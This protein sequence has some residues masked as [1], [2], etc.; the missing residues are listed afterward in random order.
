MVELR[1]QL[2]YSQTKRKLAFFFFNIADSRVL[3]TIHSIDF[4]VIGVYLTVV[5][6]MGIWIGRGK[7][8]IA[9]YLL[10]GRN[11]PWWAL[12]GSIVATETS[13]VT[14]LSIPGLTY[15]E[16][17]DLR[18]LQLALGFLVGRG[19]IVVLLLPQYFRGRPFTAYQVLDRRFG[20]ATKRTASVLFLITRNLADG[21]RLFLTA[22]VLRE[23]VGWSLPVCILIIGLTTIVYT[24]IGGM[25][26]VVWNDC[27]Q[28]IVYLAGGVGALVIITRALPDGWQQLW[29]FA[30][31]HDKLRL[32][33]FRLDLRDQFTFWAGVVGGTFLSLGTHGTDQLMVQRYLC[34]RSQ[35][36]A[37][38]A[39]LLSGFA[40][41]AQFALFLLIGIGL[42]CYDDQ[43][44]SGT[45]LIH[46]DQVFAAF[47][48]DHLPVGLAGLT[49]AA[50]FAAAMSRLSSSLN[51]S[52]T[53]TVNDLYLSVARESLSPEHLVAI[54]R[55]WTVVFGLIQIGVGIAAERFA[56]HVVNDVLA[57]AG[58]TTGILLGV[59]LLGVLT[60]RVGQTAALTGM[61]VGIT[62][63]TYV[64]FQT[65]LAW[66]WYA[67]VG[68]TATFAAGLAASLVWTR[69]MSPPK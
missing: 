19:L 65:E 12:L 8:G 38:R 25:K 53:S 49:L 39:L 13:T 34:A 58:F 66:P 27:L 43:F 46:H 11:L 23:M 42:A 10:A 33:D 20:P 18:F 45:A 2:S 47:I 32:F 28:L 41:L 48:V 68:A 61:F 63:M 35:R 6:L 30:E 64:K 24:T 29:A 5:L 57:I 26:S 9:D 52:A 51:S 14:F 60:R 56:S 54:S 15:A 62:T 37:G 55:R 67:A 17:G 59:F 4:A 44:R 3:L 21:L 1:A 16:S 50:V 7:Q 22:I 40:V 36:D 31:Q 69:E